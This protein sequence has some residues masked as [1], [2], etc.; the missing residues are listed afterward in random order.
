[1]S[2]QLEPIALQDL[3]QVSVLQPDGWEA[4]SDNFI[5]HINND[6]THPIKASFDTKIVGLGNLVML[7]GSAWITHV[8]VQPDYQ[9]EGIGSRIVDE[10]INMAERANIPSIALMASE[11]GE[12]IYRKAGFRAVSEYIEFSQGKTLTPVDKLNDDILSYSPE[13]KNQILDLDQRITGEDREYLLLPFLEQAMVYV[14][15]DIVEGYHLPFLGEGPVYAVNEKAGHALMELHYVF[16]EKVVVPSEST[17]AI[18]Y[19]EQQG[20]QRV[21]INGKRMVWGRD[22]EWH[23]ENI[24]S[25]ING[26]F[27]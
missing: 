20:F 17:S 6:Y 3:S 16:K 23:P 25:R 12:P 14:N 11:M 1:M 2:I 26:A 21:G 15:N 27:G 8:I 7:R 13:Y 22:L 19:L 4:I 10:L 24:Y 9:G 5:Q 18:A